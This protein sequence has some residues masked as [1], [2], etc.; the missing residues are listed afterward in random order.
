MNINIKPTIVTKFQYRHL[1]I[2]ML[3]K[4][5]DKLRDPDPMAS[6][7][8]EFYALDVKHFRTF[9]KS[10]LTASV[11][12]FLSSVFNKSKHK[13]ELLSIFSSWG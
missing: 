1:F 7:A 6:K 12:H 10:L 8:K 5:S 4:S 2:H 3:M 13:S 11:D 9:D